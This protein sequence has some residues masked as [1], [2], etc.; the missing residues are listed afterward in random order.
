MDTLAYTVTQDDLER[1][2][3]LADLEEADEDEV[4]NLFPLDIDGTHGAETLIRELA[5]AALSGDGEAFARQVAMDWQR[6]LKLAPGDERIVEVVLLGYKLGI[7]SGNS[8]CMNDLGA[9]YYRGEL[10]EQDYVKAAE[11][12]EM[13]AD[14]GCQQSI[15][16]LGYIYEY[17]RTGERNLEKAFHYYAF[18]AALGSSSEATYKLGDMYSRGIS[19]EPDLPKAKALW[20]RS[21]ELAHSIT[22]RAQPA[23]RLARLLID[24]QATEAGIEFDP[25]QALSLY[26]QAEI[27]LRIDITE[28]GMTYYQKRL[29][30]AI[31]GQ[32]QARALLTN[33]EPEGMTIS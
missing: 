8:T 18:A 6:I 32:A 27:G 12:Y 3:A 23:I 22:E 10:V 4:S 26:Q 25:L 11:L 17:G 9:L 1:I 31:E 16:N 14:R 13:A 33:C 15:I 19:G 28:N 2:A 20:D 30:E 24:P 7:S 5:E 29:Q 21:F